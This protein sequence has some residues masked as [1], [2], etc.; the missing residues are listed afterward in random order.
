MWSFTSAS[1]E[2][3]IFLFPSFFFF[4]P[5]KM[6]TPVEDFI[7]ENVEELMR[8]YVADAALLQSL[9]LPDRAVVSQ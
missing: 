3:C 7:E 8:P 1:E 4:S 5:S 2:R 6:M 9:S